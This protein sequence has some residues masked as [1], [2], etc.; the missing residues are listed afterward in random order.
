MSGRPSLLTPELVE[1][2]AARVAAGVPL[3]EAVRAAGASPRS[4]RRWQAA[5][6]RELRELSAEARLVLALER[7][8]GKRPED[9]QSVA[10][11]LVV[12]EVEWREL[13]AEPLD[14]VL[15]EFGEE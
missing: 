5:G 1:E 15:A 9:W 2:L 12:N 7:A 8:E 4:L 11:R 3:G 10:A 14:D 6:R 13:L